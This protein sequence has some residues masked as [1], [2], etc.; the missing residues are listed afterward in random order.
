[1]ADAEVGYLSV[2]TIRKPHGVRGELA[3]ALETDRPRAVFR[4][5]RVLELGDASGRPIGSRITVQKARPANDGMILK[6]AEFDGRTPELEGLRGR[7]LLILADQAAPADEGEVHY[8]DLV[9]LRVVSDAK[10]VGVVREV[11]ETAA[12]E[13]LAVLRP[14]RPELLIPFVAA[15]IVSI[16][17]ESG[18]LRLAL[19]Q[20][21]LEL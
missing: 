3:I 17:R 18:M 19:P 10:E 14:D 15:W 8:R 2:A 13:M 11:L 1:M 4:P 5:G 9:G 20:G 7:T 6:A 16:D 12:G 21:L